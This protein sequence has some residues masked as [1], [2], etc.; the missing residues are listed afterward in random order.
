MENLISSYGNYLYAL[1]V[2]II[3]TVSAQILSFIL[4]G[5]VKKLVDKS[6]AKLDDIILKSLERPMFYFLV[7][8]G[9]YFGF[10]FLSLS[11]KLSGFLE[12]I[13]S[14]LFIIDFFY[15]IILFID[16]SI[17][18]YL[19]PF[20]N[21]T[22]TDLD[23]N[24]IPVIRKVVKVVL[25][26]FA[27]I[28]ILEK[29]GY[30]VTSLVAGL[31]IGGLAFAFAAKDM[32]GNLFGGVTIFTDKPFKVGQ[33]IKILGYTGTVKEIG[34]RTTKILTL[35]GTNVIIP[36]SKIN[37]DVV[38]NVSMEETRKVKL[39]LNLAYNTKNNKIKKA[40]ELINKIIEK[41]EYTTQKGSVYFT[42][43]NE[44]SLNLLIIYRIKN[45]KKLLL[46]KDEIHLAIKEAFEKEKIEFA[47][48]TQ[49][50]YLKK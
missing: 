7:L 34:L 36:N 4:N 49:T 32:I 38:E 11:G 23:D 29:F 9:V 42:G 12:N 5:F 19:K 37:N 44:S 46:A 24:L 47:Y 39:N 22:K 1:L 33:L 18:Y 30:D 6:K 3:F 31:G 28:I 13:I 2:I 26:I 27:L 16:V 17:T 8:V 45:T 40:K 20:A 10:S 21:R 50:L 41:N 48:P 35:D 43:F 14:I 15:F 25:V